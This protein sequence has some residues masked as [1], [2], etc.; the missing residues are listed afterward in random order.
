MSTL[1]QIT[2]NTNDMVSRVEFSSKLRSDSNREDPSFNELDISVQIARPIPRRGVMVR[3]LLSP[4]SP[5]A[6]EEPATTAARAAADHHGPSF[7]RA[8][9]ARRSRQPRW[10][11][12]RKFENDSTSAERCDRVLCPCYWFTSVYCTSSSAELLK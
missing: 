1:R 7:V 10:V 8:Y 2:L 5:I 4:T 3:A 11:Q 12:I 9:W 6:I